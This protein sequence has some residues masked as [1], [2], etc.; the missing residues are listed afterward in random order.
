MGSDWDSTSHIIK[1]CGFRHLE[2]RHSAN[3]HP[4]RTAQRNRRKA[5]IPTRLGGLGLGLFSNLRRAAYRITALERACKLHLPPNVSAD[6]QRLL[7]T[8]RVA[9]STDLAQIVNPTNDSASPLTTT[10][11]LADTAALHSPSEI[12]LYV[13]RSLFKPFFVFL[14][15]V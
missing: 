12:I 3:F 2:R 6:I 10:R 7:Q 14:F 11:I 5:S 15:A 13:Y 8:A 4:L 9:L 1:I